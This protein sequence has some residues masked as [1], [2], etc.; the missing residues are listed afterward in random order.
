MGHPG[1]K[2]G[3]VGNARGMVVSARLPVPGQSHCAQL[4]S[5]ARV[6]VEVDPSLAV[7]FGWK[8]E[9]GR[10]VAGGSSDGCRRSPLLR[11]EC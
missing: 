11:S 8:P 9:A 7:P 5:L 4:L 1:A 3:T 2:A 10:I 6:Y